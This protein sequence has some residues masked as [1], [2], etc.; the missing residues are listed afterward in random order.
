LPTQLVAVDDLALQVGLVHHVEIDNADAANASGGQIQQQRRP[1][2]A[3][4]HAEHASGLEPL[5]PL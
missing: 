3:R 1:Q 4:A 2:A 5:L